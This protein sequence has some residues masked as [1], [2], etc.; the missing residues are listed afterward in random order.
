MISV[1][2][3]GQA[4]REPKPSTVK[5]VYAYDWLI[6]YDMQ[7]RVDRQKKIQPESRCQ[8]LTKYLPAPLRV[9]AEKEGLTWMD[10]NMCYTAC[11]FERREPWQKEPTSTSISSKSVT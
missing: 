8:F 11:E 4:L 2:V 7:T 6:S 9:T 5:M 10:W 1:Q 3:A